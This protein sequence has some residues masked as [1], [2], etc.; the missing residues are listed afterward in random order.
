M[1]IG[2]NRKFIFI[3]N[4]KSASSAIEQTLK[5]LSEIVLSDSPFDKHIPFSMIEDTFEWVFQV[6]PR[7]DFLIFGVMRDPIDVMLSLY[8]S[9]THVSFRIVFPR[10][11]TGGM[12]FD[13]FLEQW[14]RENSNQL[15]PQ[16]TRFLDRN[17]AI[18][19]N[20]IIAYDQLGKGLR[21]ISSCIE[22]PALLKLPAVNVSKRRL[23]RDDLTKSQCD[24]I[25]RQFAEDDR[26]LAEFC[27]RPLTRADQQ[28]WQA[29]PAA[30]V[31]G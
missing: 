6:I 25:A 15:V 31:F 2:L 11:Y 26:F 30:L 20:Y 19:A 18:A 5:P 21:Y 28:A 24:W 12:N 14:C 8:N 1:L 27:N 13:R 7:R 3:A 29:T 4:L 17:G 16:H 22:A 9:H 23:R 10:L